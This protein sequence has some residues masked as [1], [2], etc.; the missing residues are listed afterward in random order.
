ML[1]LLPRESFLLP[2]FVPR[3]DKGFDGLY[4]IRRDAGIRV[5]DE[6]GQIGTKLPGL[7]LEAVEFLV[8]VQSTN[9]QVSCC[10][11][12]LIL[13]SCQSEVAECL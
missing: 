9:S 5:G 6:F 2:L 7:M 1:R 4:V 11:S 13:C 3:A 10:K 12:K 8:T